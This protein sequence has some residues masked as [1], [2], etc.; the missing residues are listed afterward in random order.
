VIIKY[1]TEIRSKNILE[2][3]GFERQMK[4]SKALFHQR[5]DKNALS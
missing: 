3:F 4:E 5:M 1:Q 2:D